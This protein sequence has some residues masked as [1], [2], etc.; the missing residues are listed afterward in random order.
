MKKILSAE[1]FHTQI[2]NRLF[3]ALEPLG[4]S[5]NGSL[6]I[7]QMPRQP[8]P[9]KT[10]E[11]KA[12]FVSARFHSSNKNVYYFEEDDDEIKSFDCFP[13]HLVD[14]SSDRGEN[15]KDGDDVPNKCALVLLL[16]VDSLA[17]LCR[18][19]RTSSRLKIIL[20]LSSRKRR[21][22]RDKSC[23]LF[24]ESQTQFLKTLSSCDNYSFPGLYTDAYLYSQP[25]QP[26]ETET[27]IRSSPSKSSPVPSQG[28][29]P[30]VLTFV[31]SIT[32]SAFTQLRRSRHGALS[33]AL[34]DVSFSDFAHSSLAHS[35]G[36][37]ATSR[38]T[39]GRA[40][41]L[42]SAEQSALRDPN[43]RMEKWRKVEPGV[44]NKYELGCDKTDS[45]GGREK[46]DSMPFV[47]SRNNGSSSREFANIDLL[48]KAAIYSVIACVFIYQI[49]TKSDP[50]RR[51]SA[52]VFDDLS[53]FYEEERADE[54]LLGAIIKL[55]VAG[56]TE[57]FKLESQ[58]GRVLCLEGGN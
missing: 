19:S 17:L 43:R 33:A 36:L 12:K 45:P 22:R 3:R 53:W 2:Q 8:E 26:D 35:P 41:S 44:T 48:C 58:L 14:F 29:S 27:Q 24:D 38:E 9:V 37:V 52:A 28:R 30:A 42:S 55:A 5:R 4:I 10:R 6:S 1:S 34:T 23:S 20:R 47:N 57:T 7:R 25:C 21:R 40:S 51:S 46:F 13:P 32:P 18:L 11:V 15:S 56:Q 16:L 39:R 54:T 50:A 31:R 49:A